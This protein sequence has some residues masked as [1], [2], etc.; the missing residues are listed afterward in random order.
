MPCVHWRMRVSREYEQVRETDGEE[1]SE[2]QS[3]DYF[4]ALGWA[5]RWQLAAIE[6]R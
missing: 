6:C 3:S 5:H 1:H 4:L 2:E